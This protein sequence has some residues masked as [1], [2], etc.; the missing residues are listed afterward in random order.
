MWSKNIISRKQGSEM[1]IWFN[2]GFEV[3]NILTHFGNSWCI[4]RMFSLW[5]LFFTLL[6]VPLL[7]LH[8]FDDFPW[9]S[10]LSLI[11]YPLKK[12]EIG[13][14]TGE[15]IIYL[16]LLFK[17]YKIPGFKLYT[18]KQSNTSTG[19]HPS[20][21]ENRPV[22]TACSTYLTGKGCESKGYAEIACCVALER[23]FTLIQR[24]ILYFFFFWHSVRELLSAFLPTK[25]YW[26]FYWRKTT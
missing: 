18:E 16:R 23:M 26:F 13:S 5:S 20:L 3:E 2:I 17:S 14:L 7:F 24:H 25:Q 8:S 4:T 15:D 21:W 12:T 22:Q 11:S 6:S 9:F 19:N 1:S 10:P